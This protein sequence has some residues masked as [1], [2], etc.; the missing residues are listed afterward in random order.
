MYW[1][2]TVPSLFISDAKMV[3][4][5][6]ANKFGF[7]PRLEASGPLLSPFGGG[8][9]LAN[10]EEWAR[11]RRVVSPAFA[12][13]KLKVRMLIKLIFDSYFWLCFTNQCCCDK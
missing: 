7:F 2:G 3:K 8:L 9:V 12:M 1:D 10:G 5:V 13:D 6:L 4:Q 11:H